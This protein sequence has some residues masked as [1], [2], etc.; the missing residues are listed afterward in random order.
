MITPTHPP[1]HPHAV[2]HGLPAGTTRCT[3][4]TSN[5]SSPGQ[6]RVRE[7]RCV[8]APRARTGAHLRTRALAGSA[9][10]LVYRLLP[11]LVSPPPPPLLPRTHARTH[12]RMHARTQAA[13]LRSRSG[14]YSGRGCWWAASSLVACPWR[15]LDCTALSGS[16][17]STGGGDIH[18]RGR[19]MRQLCCAV[20]ACWLACRGCART[21]AR[22]VA[23]MLAC[24]P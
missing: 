2:W 14:F 21:R 5:S 3:R 19:R 12:A 24:A 17:T 8:R 7:R 16:T 6:G 22:A 13:W 9:V 20:P 23:A 11:R 18:T 1:T 4:S 15:Q 10:Q